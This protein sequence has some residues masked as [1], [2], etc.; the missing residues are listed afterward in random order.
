MCTGDCKIMEQKQGYPNL[1]A[2]KFLCALLIVVIHT[3]PL[4]NASP[5]AHFYVNDVITRV[6]VPLFFAMSGFLFFR[7]LDFVDGKIARTTRNFACILKATR[8]NV[9]LYIIWSFLYLIVVLPEW[10][11]TGWWGLHAVKDWLYSFLFSG[12]YYHLWY[13]LALIVALPALYVLLMFIPLKRFWF[14]GAGL[15][16]LECLTYSYSWIGVDRIPL[17]MTIGSRMPVVF[18]TFFRAVPL[19]SIGAVCAGKQPK[20]TSVGLCAGAFVLCAVEAS[21]LYFFSPN[22]SQFSYL[23]ATPL[24]TCTLLNVL[25]YGRQIALPNPWPSRLRDMSLLIYCLHPMICYFFREWGFPSGIP[26]WL[27]VTVTVVA[28]SGI[29]ARLKEKRFARCQLKNQS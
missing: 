28:V 7:K 19:L 27:A 11:R 10:Y 15:W 23:F 29:R 18:D 20:R 26:F 6:A 8:K 9:L 17:V 22:E 25:V 4:Q 24:L 16:V 1:D 2:A 14:V 5:V 13:L 21:L 12:A 3:S